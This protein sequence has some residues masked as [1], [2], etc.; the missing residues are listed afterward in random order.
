MA[1]L[2]I[3]RL[4]NTSSSA[5]IRS[6]NSAATAVA[7]YNDKLA[8]L[9]YANSAKTD[10][11]FA[12]YQ[13][14]L[15]GRMQN[16]SSSTSIADASK[17]LTLSQTLTDAAK[18]NTSASILRENIQIM[19]GN[20]SL[21]DK[22]NLIV[23][24]YQRAVGNGDLALAQSLES[25]AYSV[26]QSIQ[27][28]AQQASSAASALSTAKATY[29][30]EIN[31]AL[32]ESLK[33]LN[34]DIKNVGQAGANKITA[35]WVDGNRAALQSLGVVIPAGAQPNYFDLVSGVA[36][37]KY[38]ALVLKA[39]AQAPSDPLAAQ[40]TMSQANDIRTGITQLPTLGGNLTFSQL[41]EAAQDPAM[42]SYDYST[43]KYVQNTQTGYSGYNANGQLVPSYSGM[44]SQAQANKIYFLNPNQTA[45]LQSLGLNFSMNTPK[46]GDKT[47]TT[48]DGVRVQATDN[49]PQWLKDIVG[50]N[51]ITN[52]FTDSRG[53]LQFAGAS[54]N[55]DGTGRSFY[56]LVNVGGLSGVFEHLPDGSMRL[57]GGNY[58][59]NAGAASLL[60]NQAQ[61]I[62][63]IHLQSQQEQ[64]A[65]AQKLSLAAPAPIQPLK[66][67]PTPVAATTP[68]VQNTIS[69]QKLQPTYNPQPAT[70]NPQQTAQN[71]NT[72]GS[73]G[74]KLTQP[75]LNGIKL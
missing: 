62:Q 11:D 28:Q 19:S 74:I 3:P 44:A 4:G 49:T 36:T 40:I 30:G 53:N 59:F 34:N 25:Q 72:S 70:Y 20:A 5:L 64:L 23:N 69:V 57:A 52:A 14:Y 8:A 68:A 18:S 26:S 71:L 41:Q 67:S 38:N 7:E 73:G 61:Q 31:S 37:A 46:N 24:Q 51:G 63:Q 42:F 55:G 54:T 47:G 39:Q 43:G 9:T 15:N 33:Q 27:Y 32:D 21:S 45:E 50:Q 35:Q 75:T 2:S 10:A 13:T 6:A 66:V 58:G 17:L 29:Q 60:V 22:Y 48:G 65:Q 12:Q 16:L 1:S 56:T